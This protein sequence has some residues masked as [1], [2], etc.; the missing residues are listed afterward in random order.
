MKTWYAAHIVMIVEFTRAK[1]SRFPAWENIVLIS[2]ESA[3]E[4]Y[5]KADAYGAAEAGD[6][7]DTFHWAGHPARWKFAGVRKVTECRF[8]DDEP[9]DLGEA[10]YLDLE[11]PSQAAVE[12]YIRGGDQQVLIR[13]PFFPDAVGV[14]SGESTKPPVRRKG[15]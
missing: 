14:A 10:T 11:F 15:A 6:V 13:D 12:S 1:Q 8:L 7:D 9:G 5:Q 3:D 2:A 4:A